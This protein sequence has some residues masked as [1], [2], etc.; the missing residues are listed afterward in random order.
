MK[1]EE[2]AEDIEEAKA[3]VEDVA[4]EEEGAGG[5][6]DLVCRNMRRNARRRVA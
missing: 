4:V 2:A 1:E 5:E 6:G 3:E